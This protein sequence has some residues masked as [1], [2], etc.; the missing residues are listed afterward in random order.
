MYAQYTTVP[1]EKSMEELRLALTKFG[2]K[3]LSYGS[4]D[5]H[6]YIAF[7]YQETKIKLM[8][9]MPCPPKKESSNAA[10]KKYEQYRRTKWRQIVLC[11]KAKMESIVSGIETFEE[12]FLPHIVLEDGK[13]LGK[14]VLSM[15]DIHRG[16]Q[17]LKAG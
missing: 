3:D 15:I 11:I 14:Q 10:V 2:A 13:L 6:T 4:N 1:V 8:F 16:T 5:G 12:A 7:D 9:P 17:N